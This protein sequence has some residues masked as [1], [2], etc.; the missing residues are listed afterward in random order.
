MTKNILL[1]DDEELITKSLAKLLNSK[2]YSATIASSWH[3]ALEKAQEVD[4]DLVV[5][6]VRMPD[7]NGIETVRSLLLYFKKKKNRTVPGIIIITG[8]ADKDAFE[9]ARDLQIKA[10]LHKPFEMDTFL[11][12]VKKIIG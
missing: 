10:F 6:D 12:L 11:Q 4:F 5:S 2:G 3:Q 7:M 1:V 8:Y 9:Q